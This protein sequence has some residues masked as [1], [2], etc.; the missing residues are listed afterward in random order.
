MLLSQAV[1][2]RSGVNAMRWLDAIRKRRKLR[3]DVSLFAQYMGAKGR[4]PIELPANA[5]LWVK[6]DGPQPETPALLLNGTKLYCTPLK[7]GDYYSMGWFERG[8]IVAI[9]D[10]F[11]LYIDNGLNKI[12]IGSV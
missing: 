1:L 9:Q 11:T 4:D 10:S 8:S 3:Q 5:T 6:A 12:Q 2:T 7:D